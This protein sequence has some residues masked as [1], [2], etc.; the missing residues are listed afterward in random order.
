MI[1]L[2]NELRQSLALAT[3]RGTA[4]V[5]VL[6]HEGAD[7]QTFWGP[8]SNEEPAYLVYSLTKTVLATLVLM[9]CEE[10]ELNL[11]APLATW[12]PHI[13]HAEHISLRQLLNHTA[14]IPDYGGIHAYQES[15]R[16]SPSIPWSFERFAAE[17]FEKGLLFEPGKGWAY[18]NPGYMLVKRIAEAV[19]GVSLRTLVLERIVVPLGLQRTFVPETLG[20]LSSLAPGTSSGLAPDHSPR[21]VRTHYHPGWVS[22]GVVASTSSDVVRFLDALFRGRIL[23]QQ[24]LDQMCELVIV[25]GAP[26]AATNPLSRWGRPS[27]GLGLMGDPK[28]PWGLVLGHNGGGPCYNASAFYAADLGASVCVLGAIEKDFEAE[29]LV[30]EILDHLAHKRNTYSPKQ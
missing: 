5:S 19:A 6:L 18:S 24:S 3:S 2:Q 27:Y 1:D 13:A 20:D 11:D 8:E 9:L 7:L 26:S 14:G 17:T 22:H 25:P 4:S 30:F 10:E 16:S 29:G 28:S 15:V 21:D 23:S 12:F